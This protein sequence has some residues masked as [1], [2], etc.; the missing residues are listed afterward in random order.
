MSE[1]PHD[2]LF[3]TR[4]WVLRLRR[5]SH[6]RMAPCDLPGLGNTSLGARRRPVL[7]RGPHHGR[8]RRPRPQGNQYLEQLPEHG[9][10]QLLPLRLAGDILRQVRVGGEGGG[11]G[12]LRKG[13]GDGW[14]GGGQKVVRV[15]GILSLS[16]YFSLRCYWWN[17]VIVISFLYMFFI[18]ILFEKVRY[19]FSHCE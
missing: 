8:P 18:V 11:G 13:K 14:G 17:A 19:Q 10:L 6:L 15:P 3:P 2:R 12:G 5:R 7:P 1:T 4:R 9:A 16:Y